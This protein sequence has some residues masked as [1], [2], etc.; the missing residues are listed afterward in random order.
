M[1]VAPLSWPPH[2]FRA[3]LDTA[4]SPGFV[5]DAQLALA[6]DAVAV[7]AARVVRPP[8]SFTMQRR[9]MRTESDV[10]RFEAEVLQHR[11]GATSFGVS[12]PSD[13]RSDHT[14]SVR[15][16]GLGARLGSGGVASCPLSRTTTPSG[17]LALGAAASLAN[18]SEIGELET[19]LSELHLIPGGS[20]SEHLQQ[21][22]APQQQEA[23][24]GP[25]A[26]ERSLEQQ[27]DQQPQAKEQQPQQDH[28]TAAQPRQ[29]QSLTDILFDSFKFF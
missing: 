2:T 1:Q 7:E 10:A 17:S 28:P 24:D 6:R 16:E 29:R 4:L 21:P 27:S 14:A 22:E 15:L 26:Q 19:L 8:A 25:A 12:A 5:S 18:L 20:G 9:V 13:A 11:G 23:Q 3:V